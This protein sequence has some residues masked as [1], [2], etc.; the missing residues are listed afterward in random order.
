VEEVASF[1]ADNARR[2]LGVNAA[3]VLAVSARAALSAKLEASTTT[4]SGFFGAMV[5]QSCILLTSAMPGR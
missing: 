3:K 5:P 2:V 4:R 1:V